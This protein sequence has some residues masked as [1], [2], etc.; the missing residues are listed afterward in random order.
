MSFKVALK[1]TSFLPWIFRVFF[2]PTFTLLS[3]RRRNQMMTIAHHIK[4][5]L[6]YGQVMNFS[7]GEQI[8]KMMEETSL[9]TMNQSL[10]KVIS[11]KIVP[12][13]AVEEMYQLADIEPELFPSSAYL[14]QF[15]TYRPLVNEA[16][17]KVYAEC[18]RLIG[19]DEYNI[20]FIVPWLKRGGAD[21]GTLHHISAC[22]KIGLRSILITTLAEESPWLHRVPKDVPTVE[23]GRLGRELTE[24]QRMIVLVRLVL[25]IQAPTI[26][27]IQSQLGWEMLK[28]H[29]KSLINTNK[30]VFASLY[31]DDLDF[32]GQRRGY[33]RYYLA[34]TLPYL[35]GVICDSA[36]YPR[37]LNRQYGIDRNQVH[38]VYFPGTSTDAQKHIYSDHGNI[39]WASRITWQKRPDL[40]LKIAIAMPDIHFHVKGHA[41]SYEEKQIAKKIAQLRNVTFSGSYEIGDLV[42][43]DEQFSLFLYTSITDG[44]PNVLLEA[45]TAGLP[46]VASAVGGVPDLISE[47]SG[48][49]IHNVN[50]V[51]A[52]VSV[53]RRALQHPEER[54]KRWN[55][56]ISMVQK[57]HTFESFVG[58]LARINGYFY[59]EPENLLNLGNVEDELANPEEE[60]QL[61]K[62]VSAKVWVAS[63]CTGIGQ[64]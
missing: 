31:G 59:Q 50:S 64:I 47:E 38:T 15:H 51:D 46:I 14:A 41:E 23:L 62:Q 19:N 22:K 12:P 20:I 63:E 34:S 54:R 8:A 26:H 7:N 35:R 10:K 52:Y 53:I 9:G 60:S 25:Q 18:R 4:S 6:F 39:L 43:N 30:S 37:E 33:A 61:R 48:Y 32:T 13:W 28:T 57:R 45:T 16:P 44:M 55:E 3:D 29:G 49:P 17:G 58:K 5:T 21:L 11:D 42:E 1:P 40:L 2:K 27:I 24:A 36:Y 56:A